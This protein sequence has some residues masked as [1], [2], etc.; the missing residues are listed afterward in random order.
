[1]ENARSTEPLE[2]LLMVK[3]LH[4]PKLL[5]F[6]C[7]FWGFR[8]L[9]IRGPDLGFVGFRVK[10]LRW[11]KISFRRKRRGISN[12]DW[13]KG[14]EARLGCGVFLWY[15]YLYHK[16]SYMRTTKKHY[17]PSFAYRL[18]CQA[19]LSLATAC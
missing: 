19:S 5:L 16:Y 10:G 7:R 14:L 11:Y 2:R 9:G 4:L 13:S 6:L 17:S 1:M 3:V 12:E 18:L 15:I 8:V